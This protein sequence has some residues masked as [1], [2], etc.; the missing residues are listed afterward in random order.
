MGADQFGDFEPKERTHKLTFFNWWV[1]SIFFGTLFSD[2]F[3]VYIEDTVDWRLGYSIL[4]LILLMAI[5]AFVFGT[6]IY[7]HKPRVESPLTRMVKV[8][9]TTTR[10]WNTSVPVDPNE[11]YELS[12]DHYASPRKYR[13]DHSSFVKVRPYRSFSIYTYLD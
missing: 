3:L 1:F 6:L 8:L 13:I 11:L 9:V 2:T 5:I 10:K 7:I 4:T 12:L